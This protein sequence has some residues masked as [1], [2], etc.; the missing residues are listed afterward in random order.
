MPL[1]ENIIILFY[2]TAPNRVLFSIHL[3]Q[4]QRSVAAHEEQRHRAGAR[5][6]ADG[7]AHIVDLHLAV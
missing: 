4:R 2:W 5:V 6:G 7:G 1:P 3:Q